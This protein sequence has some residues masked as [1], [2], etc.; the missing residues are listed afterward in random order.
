MIFATTPS[1]KKLRPAVVLPDPRGAQG[2]KRGREQA[3][4]L[5]MGGKAGCD[6]AAVFFTPPPR[7]A[8]TP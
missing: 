3:G 1:G 4:Y 7:E 5:S 2:V 8:T 6:R